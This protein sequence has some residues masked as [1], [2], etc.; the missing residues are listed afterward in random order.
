MLKTMGINRIVF[1][2][3]S[4]VNHYT[5]GM[6][7]HDLAE[8]LGIN[9]ENICDLSEP[10]SSNSRIIRTTL[11]DCHN[12]NSSLYVIGITFIHRYELPILKEQQFQQI[13]RHINDVGDLNDGITIHDIEKFHKLK[14]KF[15]INADKLMLID[16]LYAYTSMIDSLLNNGH[17]VVLFNTAEIIFKYFT[18]DK[19]LEY[20]NRYNK[21]IVEKFNWYS[22]Q[23]Q[24]DKGA[25]IDETD[26]HRNH[27]PD[28]CKH[29]KQG[30]HKY[31]N[32]FLYDYINSNLYV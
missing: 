1:N 16:T 21:Y 2:G 23:Y 5:A 27:I 25:M 26:L 32:E 29:I 20:I 6:G 17:K 14:T 12:N 15:E 8:K 24:L 4:Y 11:E 31:L 7:G 9:K 22:N 30:E 13:N 28:I 3:C 19:D 10:G 18:D